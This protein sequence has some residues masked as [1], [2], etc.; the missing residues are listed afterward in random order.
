[1]YRYGLTFD[2]LNT[3]MYAFRAIRGICHTPLTTIELNKLLAMSKP[4]VLDW[5]ASWCGPCKRISPLVD[6]L[7]EEYADWLFVKIDVDVF[8]SEAQ[9]A[10]IQAMPTFQ[11]EIDSEIREEFAGA[12][13]ER[14]KDTLEDLSSEL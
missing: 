9:K 5:T 10:G 4:K 3:S 1:M 8:S 11:F 13:I 7:S 6:E 14:L 12:D 2:I